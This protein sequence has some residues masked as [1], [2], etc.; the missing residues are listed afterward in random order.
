MVET[1]EDTVTI[2]QE[3]YTRLQDVTKMFYILVK[4]SQRQ[5]PGSQMSF[6][7]RVFKQ[8]PKRLKLMFEKRHGR[9]FAWI[10]EKAKDRKK[11]SI[12]T[13]PSR[14]LITPN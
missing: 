7:L 9:L 2:T 13:L 5:S 1:N 6:D 3:E 4:Q 14:K 10:P 12:L 11:K 8:L